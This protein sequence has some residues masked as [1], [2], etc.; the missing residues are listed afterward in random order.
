MKRKLPTLAEVDGPIPSPL[1][2]E[3]AVSVPL[4]MPYGVA[5][6]ARRNA[7]ALGLP[8]SRFI[9]EAVEIHNVFVATAVMA[10]DQRHETPPAAEAVAGRP[11][12]SAL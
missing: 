1:P 11:G 7:R 6:Q 9:R 10:A 5:K 12:P 8:L 4:S 2:D 3:R